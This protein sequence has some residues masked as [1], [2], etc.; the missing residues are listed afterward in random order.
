MII[1]NNEREGEYKSYHENGQLEIICN[2]KN[3]KKE[4]GYKEYYENCK[5]REIH[6]YINGYKID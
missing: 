4:G 5:L 2:Y 1:I 6:N 3:D